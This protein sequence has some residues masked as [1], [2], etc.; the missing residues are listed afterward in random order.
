MKATPQQIDYLMVLFNDLGYSTKGRHCKTQ[1]AFG[2]S[3]LDEL[4]KWQASELIAE[5]KDAKE[6]R[7]G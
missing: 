1:L 7:M 2:V 3:A 5:L 6:Q 4:T